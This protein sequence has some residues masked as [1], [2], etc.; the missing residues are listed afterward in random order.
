MP[1]AAGA[2][3]ALVMPGTT[4]YG[5]PAA[6]QRER[7]LSAAAEHERV[8]ALQPHDPAPAP[9]RANHQRVDRLL[10]HRVAAGALADEEPLRPPRDLRSPRR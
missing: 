10:R 6:L 2:A 5:T 1:A 4:S 3:T 9:R 8:A 7:F